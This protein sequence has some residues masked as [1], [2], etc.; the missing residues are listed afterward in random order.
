MEKRSKYLGTKIN[1]WKVVDYAREKNRHRTF[2]LKKKIGF[3]IKT[4]TVREHQLVLFS[5]GK[6]ITAEIDGKAYCV[7]KNIYVPQNTINKNTRLSN[8]FRGI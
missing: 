3:S 5:R 2:F 1:G 8:L 4:M 7:S 6:T